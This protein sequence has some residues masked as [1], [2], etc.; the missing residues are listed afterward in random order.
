M[1]VV[2]IKVV[3]RQIPRTAR[4][5]TIE[6]PPFGQVSEA[7]RLGLS[8]QQLVDAYGGPIY[9]KASGFGESD[10]ESPDPLLWHVVYL[11]PPAFA[12]EA[13]AL[14]PDRVTRLTEAALET[15][16]DRRSLAGDM[17]VAVHFRYGG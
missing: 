4:G 14:W 10:P 13:E 5:A 15:F 12:D 2:P 9:D 16:Y 7:A 1:D 6:Y 11:V 17:I 8:W 3:L